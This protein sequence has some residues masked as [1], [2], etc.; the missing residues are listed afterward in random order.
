MYGSYLE[1]RMLIKET[2]MSLFLWCFLLTGTSLATHVS[3]S[4]VS[5]QSG[6]ITTVTASTLKKR[7]VSLEIQSEIINFDTF[8]D[9]EL[10]SFAEQDKKIHNINSL[11]NYSAG[12]A[13]GITDDMTLNLSIPYVVRRDIRESEPPD[14]IHEHGDAE[15]IGDIS[16]RAHRRFVRKTDMD[17]TLLAGMKVPTGETTKADDHG[18]RFETEFQPGSGSW[19]PFLGIAVT[20][21]FGK[22]SLDGN[23][24]YTLV[25]E[26]SQDT[27][28]GDKFNYNIAFAYGPYSGTTS[29]DFIIEGNGIWVAKQ[30]VNGNKDDNSGGNVVYI[31]PGVRI[32]FGNTISAYVSYG[33]PV[34]Q[35]MNGDQNE[36]D[37][38]M[39]LG[40]NAGF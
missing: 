12:I 31:S 27:D 32:S 21:R 35:D 18:E 3:V 16:L 14:E 2:I 17:M 24:L 23:V 26:G 6:P 5:G 20:K 8:S 28:L 11:L 30:D 15:G 4:S 9:R 19:D 40:I 29:V 10:V 37:Y 38:R 7:T 22:L 33:Y 1:V 39:V 13:Y 25:T 34:L 36:I